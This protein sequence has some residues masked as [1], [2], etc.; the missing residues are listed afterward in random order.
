LRKLIEALKKGDIGDFAD[1]DDRRAQVP[2]V[3]LVLVECEKSGE[4]TDERRKT[5][6]GATLEMVERIPA[7]DRGRRLRVNAHAREATAT[8]LA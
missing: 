6:V 3:R 7:R 5:A 8:T 1:L 2:F 4:M